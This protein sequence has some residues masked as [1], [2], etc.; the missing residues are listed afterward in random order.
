[1]PRKILREGLP[2]ITDV[3]AKA[4]V[5]PATVSRF[6][7]AP[8]KVKEGTRARIASV[9]DDLGYVPHA[10]SGLSPQSTGTVGLVVPT[11]DNAIF[12]EMIQEFSTT[13]FRHARVM[14]IGTH[15]YDLAREAILTESLLQN[16]V[17]AIG[18]IG[19]EHHEQTIRQLQKHDIP[20]VML[21]N[22][23]NR[24]PWPCIGIDNR[25]VGNAAVKH[26]L[27]LGHRDILLLMGESLANDR[28]ADRRSGAL[29]AMKAAGLSVPAHRRLVCP[30]EVQAC[31]AIVIEALA[32]TPRPTAIF[33]ANDVIAQG[34]LFATVSLGISVPD[35]ISI[36]GIGDF[37]GSSA[38]VPGLTTIRVPARRIG[39]RAAEAIVEM[40]NWPAAPLDHDFKYTAEFII[41]GSTASPSKARLKRR[42]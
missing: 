36:I 19:L 40:I 6:F 10:A 31:K 21:W 16:R 4:N 9:V 15:G 35:E 20:A 42:S 34:A 41:R 37:R 29:N 14:L 11:I 25:E 12:A 3:A 39:R 28:A 30:Y 22:Y 17:D 2:S 24:Q 13:L 5:S 18:L 26:L 32:Q 1:M 7:N 38:V 8:E 33:A 27:E 23:R